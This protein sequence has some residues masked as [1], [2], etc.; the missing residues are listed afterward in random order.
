MIELKNLT[1]GYGKEKIVSEVSR[2]F[3][4][5]EIVSV[6]GPNGAGKSTLL[7][8]IG[9]IIPGLFGEV[10]VNGK[11]T[12][13]FKKKE[14][15]KYIAYLPQG[16]IVPDMTVEQLV[17]HGRFPYTSYLKGYSKED[18]EFFEKSLEITGLSE[19]RGKDLSVLSGGMR[20]MVY[21]AMAI[22]QNT[23]FILLDEP[24]TYLDINHQ[25]KL[26]KTL[27]TL[28]KEGKGIIIIM[29]DLP[30]AFSFSDKIMILGDKREI[31][32]G[33]PEE[34]LKSG[35]IKEVF[36]INFSE[37]NGKYFYEI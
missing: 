8:T 31:S 18:Y 35:I 36:K 25:I 3:K 22:C 32:Y 28:K 33:K 1:C 24:V 27:S 16:R 10:Y 12:K 20:Q 2:K 11:N 13:D 26:M 5:G 21:I 19:L 30:L 23:D 15:A 14:L 29:H 17:L 37:S 6:I 7:K 34:I 4:R 9:G